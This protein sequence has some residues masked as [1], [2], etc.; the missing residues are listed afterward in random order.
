MIIQSTAPAA[1]T[2]Q[3]ITSN[4]FWPEIDPAAARDSMRLD[5][6]ITAARLRTALVEAIAKTNQ[7]LATWRTGKQAEGRATLADVPAEQVDGESEHVARYRRAVYC[8]A[9][10]NLIERYRD[11]DSTGEGHKRADALTDPI[12]DL[13]RD[14][15]W[16]IRDIL[17]AGR[18]TIELI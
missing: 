12:D 14:A 16:A 4:P 11:Y 7:E 1:G 18:S 9:A 3:P 15:R 10:A 8:T 2:E 13:R 17:G 5:G 6:T